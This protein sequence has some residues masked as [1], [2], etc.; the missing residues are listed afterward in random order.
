MI[1]ASVL[2]RDMI[3]IDDVDAARQRPYS[4]RTMVGPVK[5]TVDTNVLVR[6]AVLDDPDQSPVAIKL[7]QGAETVAVTLPTLCEFAWVLS[8]GYS[9]QLR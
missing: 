8:C 6:A 7:L 5:V 3:I 4:T 2:V 1:S 9:V